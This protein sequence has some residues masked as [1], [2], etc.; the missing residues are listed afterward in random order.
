MGTVLLVQ[1]GNWENWKGFSLAFKNLSGHLLK[2]AVLFSRMICLVHW[3]DLDCCSI[4]M[5]KMTEES[6]SDLGVCVDESRLSCRQRGFEGWL[7][8]CTDRVEKNAC[9]FLVPQI[10]GARRYSFVPDASQSLS[11]P[12]VS[13][14]E[15][16][17]FSS[18]TCC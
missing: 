10:A 8:G 16:F 7:S 3:K 1:V 14:S 13:H 17:L 18:G 5:S 9:Q 2:A 6:K 15:R 12:S 4:C 11:F